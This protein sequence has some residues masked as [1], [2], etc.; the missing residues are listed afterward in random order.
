MLAE[1]LSMLYTAGTVPDNFARK[2]GNAPIVMIA[3][4]TN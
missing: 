2:P 3:L 4:C 1:L